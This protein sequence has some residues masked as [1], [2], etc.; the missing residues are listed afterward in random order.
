MKAK[1]GENAND[2]VQK[3]EPHQGSKMFRLRFLFVML[4]LTLADPIK[5]HKGP[6]EDKTQNALPLRIRGCLL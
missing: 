3:Y 6:A 4:S 5:I 2:I 1:Y